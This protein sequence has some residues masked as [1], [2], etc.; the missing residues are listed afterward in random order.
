MKEETKEVQENR[1]SILIQ[2]MLRGILAR[3]R[4]EELR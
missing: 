1:S 3:K 2:K 4:V